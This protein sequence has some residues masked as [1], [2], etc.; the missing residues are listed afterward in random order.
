MTDETKQ[1]EHRHNV[2]GALREFIPPALLRSG[3]RVFAVPRD[4]TTPRGH[5]LGFIPAGGM[6]LAV[7]EYILGC[8]QRGAMRCYE[9]ATE[10]G[11]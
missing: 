1:G 3:Q 8:A 2:G 11:A 10:G 5:K 9:L 4:A 6:E 7:N